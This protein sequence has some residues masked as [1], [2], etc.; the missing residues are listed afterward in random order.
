MAG[1]ETSRHTTARADRPYDP[2][3]I[4]S[5]E[6]W[7]S[8]AK[9]REKVFADDPARRVL[10]LAGASRHRLRQLDPRLLA[11]LAD[12]GVDELLAT[13]LSAPILGELITPL[14]AVGGGIMLAALVAFQLRR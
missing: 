1:V 9:D 4:S 5:S 11:Q 12:A 3:D 14:Q 8:T 7:A 2:A 10:D 13:L 6:F